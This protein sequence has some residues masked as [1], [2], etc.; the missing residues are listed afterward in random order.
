MADK[1]IHI[2]RNLPPR[3]FRYYTFL[4]CLYVTTLLLTGL[5]AHKLMAVSFITASAATFVYPF[6]YVFED[7]IA[8]V[9][10]YKIMRQLIW[11]TFLCM[12]VFDFVSWALANTIPPSFWNEQIA[13]KQV[14]DPMPSIFF[15]Y[16]VAMNLGAILNAYLLTK[17][18]ILTNGKYFWMRSVC[19]STIGEGIFTF[20]VFTFM[21][22]GSIPF[23]DY[24]QSMVFSYLFKFIFT[25]LM[26]FPATFIVKMLKIKEGIDVFDNQT[27][28]NPLKVSIK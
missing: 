15:S 17:W 19:S 2:L 5:T 11:I 14:I 23:K 3:A 4:A 13:Y 9:Y 8:E 1:Q 27:D 16:F 10:G 28:F 20:L 26:A 24:I 25:V 6:S 21:F 22:Y 18:K 12:M 7:V